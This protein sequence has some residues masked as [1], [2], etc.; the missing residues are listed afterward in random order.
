MRSTSFTFARTSRDIPILTVQILIA[1][2]EVEAIVESSASA[3]VIESR[4]AKK[5]SVLKRARKVKVRQGD[6]SYVSRRKY[7]VNTLISVSSCGDFVG[8]FPLDVE[9]LD[10]GK[11][12]IVL[13]L[14]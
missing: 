12:A 1:G 11:R 6:E 5:L 13:S 2:E 10:I 3:P 8:K 7:G 9:V 14:S 4:I